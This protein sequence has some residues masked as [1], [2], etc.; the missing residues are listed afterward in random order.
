MG[1]VVRPRAISGDRGIV[2][3]V[4]LGLPLAYPTRAYALALAVRTSDPYGA[5]LL[6]QYEGNFHLVRHHL[7]SGG[8]VMSAIQS[9][10]TGRLPNIL[11]T[12][13]TFKNHEKD[14]GSEMQS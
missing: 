4:T 10:D 13:C 6:G 8:A 9:H 5:V 7:H 3:S 12:W 14:G 11:Y 1:R 2:I